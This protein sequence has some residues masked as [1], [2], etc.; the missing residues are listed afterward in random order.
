MAKENDEERQQRKQI[1][2]HG[3]PVDDGD[4]KDD[5]TVL[6]EK[7]E[8]MPWYE[9]KSGANRFELVSLYQKSI[10]RNDEEVAAYCGWE[11][12][13]SGHAEKFWESTILFIVEDLRANSEEAL[14][15]DYYHRLAKERWDPESWEGR[16]TAIHAALTAA[17]APPSR[18]STHANDWFSKV[19]DEREA[20]FEEGREPEA[21]FPVTEQQLE[22]G[23]MYDVA[24][25]K[26]T[27]SGQNRG[28][29]WH[30]FFVRASRVS[31]P[32]EPELSRKWQRRRLEIDPKR[33]FSEEEIEHALKPVDPENRWEEDIVNPNEDLDDFDE[34]A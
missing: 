12:V 33:S 7:G 22:L 24:L 10:R 30:H 18:E 34:E 8:E 21:E 15:L 23:G 31:E 4:G 17:R 6:N 27:Y 1:D 28:R 25:D 32:G 2:I 13:R 5:E 9:C 29:D 14:L 19:S 16:I 26:H 20:A 11:L 3:N